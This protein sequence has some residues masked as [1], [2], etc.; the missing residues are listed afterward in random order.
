MPEHLAGT[1]AK[2]PL[3]SDCIVG[4]KVS[5]AEE[6]DEGGE[7]R[8]VGDWVDALASFLKDQ[9]DVGAVRGEGGRSGASAS[10]PL[11]L[12]LLLCRQVQFCDARE[13]I[14][15]TQVLHCWR[16]VPETKFV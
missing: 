9:L 11:V 5:V 16:Q 6:V 14:L 7:A 3:V 15:I 8:G 12:R 2:L 10:I 13:G 4:C 1:V